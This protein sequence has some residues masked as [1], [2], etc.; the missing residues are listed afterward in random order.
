MQYFDKTFF[1]FLLG[2]AIILVCGLF[3]IS[4]IEAQTLVNINTA[5]STELQTLNGIGPSKAQAI[6]DYRNQNG[7][8]QKIEDI[9]NVSGIGD[10]TFNNIKDFI[11][12]GSPQIGSNTTQSEEQTSPTE[13]VQSGSGSGSSVEVKNLTVDAGANKIGVVGQPLEFRA[14]VSHNKA[15]ITWIFGDGGTAYGEV[16][17]HTYLYPGEYVV[18]VKTSLSSRSD[19]SRINVKIVPDTLSVTYASL[20]RIEI[21]N[22][23]REEINLSG[24]TLMSLG[25]S[26]YFPED[27]IIKPA[28]KISFPSII[29]G[30]TPT[31]AGV[32][33]LGLKRGNENK[34]SINTENQEKIKEIT[35]QILSLQRKQVALRSNSQTPEVNQVASVALAD[36]QNFSTINTGTTS[37]SKDKNWIKVL[38]KF[39]GF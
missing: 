39:F 1:K 25:E 27:T 6:I 35:D 15:S 7:P 23:G 11:T 28:Q 12:V 33:S 2:F 19:N 4:R 8:F 26:F 34:V 31:G 37:P 21:S 13:N 24:R 22:T 14:E 36:I 18:V 10:A 30:L 38:K 3:F 5:L 20:D 32:V 9:Q 16:V 29:T 17:T